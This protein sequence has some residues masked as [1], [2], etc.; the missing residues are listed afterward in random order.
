MQDF[1]RIQA[2]RDAHALTL[3]IYELTASFPTDERFGLTT[4]LRRAC[5]SIGANIAEGSARGTDADFRRF[6]QIATGST[7]ETQNFVMLARDLKFL[8]LEDSKELLDALVEIKKKL[9]NF[10]KRLR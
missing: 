9:I 5:S 7:S 4:Q 8:S 3:R 1:Q 10:I 6:L 2:W